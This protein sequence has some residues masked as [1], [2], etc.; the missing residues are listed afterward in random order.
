MYFIIIFVVIIAIIVFIYNVRLP[1]SEVNKKIRH[2][3]NHLK[4]KYT[5]VQISR[6]D[7]D[8]SVINV[9]FS[10][11]NSYFIKF[12]YIPNYSQ[13]QINNKS[14]WE[15]KYGAGNTPGKH[16]PHKRY[17]NEIATF[18]NE[19]YVGKKIV[20]FTNNPKEIVKYINESEIIIVNPSTDVYGANLIS[21][22]KLDKIVKEE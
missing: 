1:K 3:E 18:L 15:L 12:V 14:T 5:N 8:K 21:V 9:V 22:H 7:T 2:Y 19:D 4:T 10:N 20:A 13:I 16:Q 17:L 11:N 6:L